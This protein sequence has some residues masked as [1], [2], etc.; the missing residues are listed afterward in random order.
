MQKPHNLNKIQE[1][2]QRTVWGSPEIHLTELPEFY[3]GYKINFKRL[4]TLSDNELKQKKIT[5]YNKKH[6][7]E[8]V[9]RTTRKV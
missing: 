5:A 3:K 8:R 1:T 6:K 4:K 7:Y 2:Q 9:S